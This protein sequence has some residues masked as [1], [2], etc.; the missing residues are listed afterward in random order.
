M[1]V[2]LTTMATNVVK[3]V[4]SCP[5]VVIKPEI[6]K[7]A[8]ELCVKS[9]VLKSVF[10]MDMDSVLINAH[11]ND[12]VVVYTGNLF[13][14]KLPVGLVSLYLDAT[15]YEL[16]Q[17]PFKNNLS[18]FDS[19]YLTAGKKYYDFPTMQQVRIFPVDSGVDT[20]TMEAAFSPTDDITEIDDKLYYNYYEALL[21][22]TLSRLHNIPDQPWTSYAL[23]AERRRKFERAIGGALVQRYGREKG[24]GR[25]KRKSFI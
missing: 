13:P 21:W 20:L 9:W 7:A 17:M 12:S 19:I 8:Q 15:E 22:G 10:E 1:A 5:S 24:R 23:A 6:V 25:P 2:S 11:A 14:D 18:Q 16:E 4:P 3:Y